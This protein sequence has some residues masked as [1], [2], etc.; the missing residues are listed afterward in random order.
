M[1]KKNKKTKK[2]RNLKYLG[3]IIAIIILLTSAIAIIIVMPPAGWQET[4]NNK[5]PQ[6]TL[7]ASYSN[8]TTQT[9][10]QKI[11]QSENTTILDLRPCTCSYKSGHIPTAQ[12]PPDD[13]TELYNN[14]NTIIVYDWGGSPI[15][16]AIDYCDRLINNTHATIYYLEGGIN[17]WINHDYPLVDGKGE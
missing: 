2:P 10:Y 4:K 7:T 11:N 14:T 15:A 1:V 13:I 3:I 16:D 8:I 5:T 12:L 6:Q 17:D 9:L